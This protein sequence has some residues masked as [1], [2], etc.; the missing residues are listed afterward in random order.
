VRGGIEVEGGNVP[1]VE[2]VGKVAE[3]AEGDVDYAVGSQMPRL[4][5]IGGSVSLCRAG[6][7]GQGENESGE[8]RVEGA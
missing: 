6:L 3:T 8:I 7:K 4:I 5:Q 2:E 1:C